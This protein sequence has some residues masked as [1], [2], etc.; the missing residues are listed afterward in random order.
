[1]EPRG[2]QLWEEDT[3]KEEQHLFRTSLRGVMPPHFFTKRLKSNAKEHMKMF[4]NFEETCLDGAVAG[5]YY[6]FQQEG[7]L[8]HNAMMVTP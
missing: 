1:M 7:I 6:V 4:Q 5:C 8:V 2:L 3:Q